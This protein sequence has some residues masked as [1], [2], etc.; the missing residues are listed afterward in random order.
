MEVSAAEPYLKATSFNLPSLPPT[1][2]AFG[3]HVRRAHHQ[4]C[5]WRAALDS[6]P[7]VLDAA[8]YGWLSDHATKTLLPVS[9]PAATMPAPAPVLSLLCCTCSTNEP[10]SSRKCS[11]HRSGMA[12]SIFCKCSIMPTANCE[13]PIH[14]N[15][16]AESD[17]DDDDE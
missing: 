7:P 6:D 8:V 12:C 14:N 2:E 10:S 9:L 17:E 15:T 16:P 3:L 1:S 5:I 13:N 4:A 11:C